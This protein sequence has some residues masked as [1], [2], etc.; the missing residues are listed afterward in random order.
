MRELEYK[1]CEV[2]VLAVKAASV[3]GEGRYIAGVASTFDGP[4][5][6]HGDIISPGAYTDSL[7]AR[8]SVPV[9]WSHDAS[10]PLGRT[11]FLTEDDA[12]GLVF[13][14]RLSETRDAD[15]MLELVRDG[16]VGMSIGYNLVRSRRGR[17]HGE[18]VRFLDAI[19]LFE[20]S[21]TA[22]AS[23]TAASVSTVSKSVVVQAV[24][25]V[26][27]VERERERLLEEMRRSEE[28]V[29]EWYAAVQRE[30]EEQRLALLEEIRRVSEES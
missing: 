17:W 8:P 29:P 30:R 21:P 20:V 10:R 16:V 7:K 28:Q 1:T 24:K 9:L 14:A 19:D 25:R 11:T 15:D 26:E 18:E 23:N 3:G 2:P 27:A 5:D 12:V 13:K 6:A 4:V 22:F